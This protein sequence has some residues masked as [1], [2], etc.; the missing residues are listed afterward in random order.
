M[1]TSRREFL[2]RVSA[3]GIVSVGAAPPA[4]LDRAVLAAESI[5][6]SEN[7]GRILVLL[8][9]A[10]GN[11]GLNTV[12]P[13]AD[14]EYRKARPGI[15]IEPQSVIKIDDAVGLHPQMTG[16]KN[17]YDAGWLKIVQGVGY[18]NPNR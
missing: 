14:P 8:Q 4:F 13:Y 15:G 6:N 7:S 5:K 2:T 11:D 16:F 1:S 17:L 18:P 12:I 9:L 3:A 10:G